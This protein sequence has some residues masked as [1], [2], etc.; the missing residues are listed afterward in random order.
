[1]IYTSVAQIFEI[2]NATRDA[3]YDRVSALTE[4]QVAFRPSAGSWSI[5][6]L[7]EHISLSER[8]L[9]KGFARL[10][11]QRE[12]DGERGT[13]FEPFSLDELAQRAAREKYSSP[14]GVR[15]RGAS[16]DQTLGE[17]RE[18]RD[19]LVALRPRLESLNLADATLQHPAFG[20][21]NLY[22]WLAFI[23]LHEERHLGQIDAVIS[24]PGFPAHK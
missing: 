18:T 14:E 11:D 10:I 13:G 7:V 16:L 8:R 21:L 17:M 2:I 3:V 5:S 6:E 12:A 19:A 15:P 1:M 22:Q 23:G 20:P 24:S 9:L 4:E